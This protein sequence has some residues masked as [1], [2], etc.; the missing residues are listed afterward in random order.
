MLAD[1][2]FHVVGFHFLHQV[3]SLSHIV[4]QEAIIGFPFG[5]P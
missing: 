5:I 1:H 3:R 2:T 4:I